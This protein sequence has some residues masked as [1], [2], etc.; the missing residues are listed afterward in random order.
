MIKKYLC[1]TILIFGFISCNEAPNEFT[2]EANA[3]LDAIDGK[4][5]DGAGAYADKST[6]EVRGT[7]I[8]EHSNN[9]TPTN[10][11]KFQNTRNNGTS[12]TEA[13]Y[14]YSRDPRK[15]V[16]IIIENSGDTLKRTSES[17]TESIDWTTAFTFATKQAE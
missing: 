7:I 3:F 5:Y 1:I 6:F 9:G 10:P 12:A 8:A 4:D 16:G 13:I 11:L 15:Y 2:T 17:D 14:Q